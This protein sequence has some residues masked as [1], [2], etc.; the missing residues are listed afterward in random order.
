MVLKKENTKV[1]IHRE[2]TGG[3]DKAGNPV[4]EEIVVE[5][6]Y[7]IP[8]APEGESLLVDQVKDTAIFKK[9]V[10]TV[11]S[12]DIEGWADGIAPGDVT[13]LPGTLGLIHSVALDIMADMR[14]GFVRKN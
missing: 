14:L 2:P 3:K 11:K 9:Y 12:N 7:R 5:V 4:F 1:Y 6:S 10:Q 8:T 13:A